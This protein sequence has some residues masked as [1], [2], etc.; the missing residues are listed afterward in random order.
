MPLTI[1]AP[2]IA[3]TFPLA[4]FTAAEGTP[5]VPSTTPGKSSRPLRFLAGNRGFV[6]LLRMQPGT[7]MPLHRHKGEVH[8]FVLQGSYLLCT[9]ERI[10]AGG[11]VYEPMGLTDWWE[12]VG[13][14]PLLVLVIVMGEAEFL[15]PD[16][17]VCER[18][19][20]ATQRAAYVEHCRTHDLP[21]ADLTEAT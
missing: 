18:V 10:D 16:G 13:D 4:R 9:G 7:V 11:Y 21:I 1:K 2:P 8:V 20:A 15:N 5:W 19:S 17:S 14:E 12:V 3:D 6:E